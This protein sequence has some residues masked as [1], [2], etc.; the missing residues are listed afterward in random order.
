MA[1]PTNQISTVTVPALVISLNNLL[2][3]DNTNN[4]TVI[5]KVLQVPCRDIL[6]DNTDRWAIPIKDSGNFTGLDFEYKVEVYEDLNYVPQPT[7]DSFTV[8]R[9]RDTKSSFEWMIYG[10]KA[11]LIKSC[12]T[13]CGIDAVPMPGISPSFSLKIA[14]CQ[15][16]DLL[17]G[18]GNPYTIFALPSLGVGQNYFPY[19]SY[20]NV[21]LPAGDTNG[22]ADVTSLLVFLN[23]TWNTFVW[24]V[25]GD[26]TSGYTLIATGGTTG[27]N[28]CVNVIP[29]T[30]S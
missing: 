3:L 19:G 12:A 16:I 17:D 6:Y 28:L 20:N 30:P 29:V 21:A 26:V 10:S 25:T 9:I 11:D 18:S 5:G 15:P 7:F 1:A 23:G 4:E 13:C 14:P 24:T 8:F 22:Y 2:F 27:Y